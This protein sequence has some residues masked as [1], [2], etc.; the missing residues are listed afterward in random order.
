MASYTADG[1]IDSDA[2]KQRDLALG[3]DTEAK[4]RTR[5]QYIPQDGWKTHGAGQDSIWTGADGIEIS[6]SRKQA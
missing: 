3:F 4:R 2:V 1:Q 6:V 5:E